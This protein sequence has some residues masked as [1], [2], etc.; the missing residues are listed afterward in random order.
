VKVGRA[1]LAAAALAAL[2][3]VL[4]ASAGPAG[5]TSPLS[6]A[7]EST[8]CELDGV[9]RIVAV[10]DVHGAYDRF[11]EILRAAGV[12]DQDRHWSGGR[13]HLVQLGDVVDRGPDSRKALDFLMSLEKE[14]AAAGGQVHALIGNHEVMRMLSDMR[15]VTPGEY[16]AFATPDSAAT[17][18]EIVNRQPEN[19]REQLMK[20]LPLG[21]IEMRR[22]FLRAGQY[23]AW[24]RGHDAVVKINGIVFLHGGI[25]PAVAPMPCQTINDT[26]RREVTEDL[27]AT[28]N[29]PLQSLAAREDGPL[30]YRGLA[31]EPEAAFAP[32]VDQ[33]LTDAHARAIVIAHTVTPTGR[34]TPRFGGRIIVMD[35]G[36]QPAY[37]PNGRA[38]ALEIAGDTRTAIY[39]DRKDPLP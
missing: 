34:V 28:L 10:G 2:S 35:T 21:S 18:E 37:V 1:F 38:S 5:A 24:L 31:Q 32:Q 30:W 15:Y 13:T 16:A 25:S 20:E 11:T 3:A 9:E 39:V 27:D 19:I 36:M 7:A 26:V 4:M 29:A 8:S 14:A 6:N 12:I 33:I 22:A 23:G 17:R